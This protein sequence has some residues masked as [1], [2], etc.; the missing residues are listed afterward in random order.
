MIR[1]EDFLGLGINELMTILERDD[2]KI[3]DETVLFEALVRSVKKL[4]S[5]NIFHYNYS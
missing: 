5:R 2:L 4:I 1:S 3:P